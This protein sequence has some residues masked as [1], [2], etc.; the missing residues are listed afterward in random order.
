[1][2]GRTATT[3]S[4]LRTGIEVEVATE[5]D[6]RADRVASLY[7]DVDRWHRT[8]EPTIRRAR[9]VHEENGVRDILVDHRMEGEVPNRLGI[10]EDGAIWLEEHKPKYDAVFFNRFEATSATT[11]RYR[12]RGHIRPTGVYRVVGWLFRPLVRRLARRR[13]TEYVLDPLRVAAER[14]HSSG[15]E[16]A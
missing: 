10:T 5:I 16:H 1:M 4:I 11:T 15:P 3:G 2:Q 13:M 14:A 12:L 8:F 9:V 6:A 7:L